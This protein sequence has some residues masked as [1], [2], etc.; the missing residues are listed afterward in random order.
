MPE[1]GDNAIYKAA[2]AVTA[3]ENFDFNVLQHPILGLPT[4]NV[5]TITGGININSVPDRT[6]ITIDIRTIPGQSSS[7]IF[8]NSQSILGE[9][10]ELECITD[11]GSL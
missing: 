9:D 8:Q 1:Q 10:V 5:G 4:L 11:A 6:T 2:R 3:L 7:K